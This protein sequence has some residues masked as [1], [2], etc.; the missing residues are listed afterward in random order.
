MSTRV[1]RSKRW[2]KRDP[3]E[4]IYYRII[5]VWN[6]LPS[7]VVNAPTVNTFKARL[8]GAWKNLPTKYD[9]KPPASGS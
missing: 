6:E 9:P 7:E 3:G 8:D 4:L 1:E 2:R 5:K